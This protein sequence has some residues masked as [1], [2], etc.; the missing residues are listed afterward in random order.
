MST[1][2][3][4][5]AARTLGCTGSTA[6]AGSFWAFCGW[7]PAGLPTVTSAA[8]A[9]VV[10]GPATAVVVTPIKV[11]TARMQTAPSSL[12]M[13][14]PLVIASA[15][16]APVTAPGLVVDL[17]CRGPRAPGRPPRGDA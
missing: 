17:P 4:A 6:S 12:L 1:R 8:D 14:Q 13:T 16:V 11:G 2:S 15:P 7:L 10:D 5:P 3:F 9:A